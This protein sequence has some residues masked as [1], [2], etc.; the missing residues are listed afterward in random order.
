MEDMSSRQI[1]T[2]EKPGGELRVFKSVTSKEDTQG[3]S[4]KIKKRT[5]QKPGPY[6]ASTLRGQGRAANGWEESQTNAVP[7][8]PRE[9]VVSRRRSC[10]TVS[11][12]AC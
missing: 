4:G 9:E 2:Q 7:W 5:Q 8:K 3:L 1:G 12:A 11:K 10:S 6:A